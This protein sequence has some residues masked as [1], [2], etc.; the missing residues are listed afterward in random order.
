MHAY[1]ENIIMQFLANILLA[2]DSKLNAMRYWRLTDQFFSK[3]ITYSLGRR[4]CNFNE[5]FSKK[6]NIMLLLEVNKKVSFEIENEL[7][8]RNRA[9]LLNHALLSH[10]LSTNS[11][12]QVMH[13]YACEVFK[14]NQYIFT[15]LHPRER[16]KCVEKMFE[17]WIRLYSQRN[18][19]SKWKEHCVTHR[20][21]EESSK[22]WCCWNPRCIWLL[23][24][25]SWIKW[26][27]IIHSKRGL[28]VLEYIQLFLWNNSFFASLQYCF[29]A[30]RTIEY[31]TI[32]NIGHQPIDD[33]NDNTCL[34][35]NAAYTFLQ[36]KFT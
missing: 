35:F 18:K 13:L 7:W 32:K 4:E 6:I 5:N 22:D 16:A 15:I 1:F 23:W 31:G 8:H 14:T 21:A 19:S 27:A 24:N 30:S 9:I 34:N 3:S 20:T 2:K 25:F 12:K 33:S 17:E 11:S 29:L 36:L 26:R 28:N 10:L